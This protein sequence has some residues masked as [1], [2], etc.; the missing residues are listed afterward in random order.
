MRTWAAVLTAVALFWAAGCTTVGIDSIPQGAKVLVDGKWNGAVTPVNVP[1][2]DLPRGTHTITVEKEGYKMVSP[3]PQVTIS[4][5]GNWILMTC[6]PPAGPLAILPAELCGNL[7]KKAEDS[8]GQISFGQMCLALDTSVLLKESPDPAQPAAGT[9]PERLIR[10]LGARNDPFDVPFIINVHDAVL[11]E[12]VADLVAQVNGARLNTGVI[13]SGVLYFS[14][15]EV[16]IDKDAVGR[17]TC[18]LPCT[19]FKAALDAFLL[20][21]RC[22][23]TCTKEQKNEKAPMAY[24]YKIRV[25]RDVERAE[26]AEISRMKPDLR[27]LLVS[28]ESSLT[29]ARWRNE[30]LVDAKKQQL[31]ALLRDSK[32]AELI[33]LAGKI[34]HTILDCARAR[35]ALKDQSQRAAEPAAQP[36]AP[37]QVNEQRE[38]SLVLKERIE[39]LAP[40]LDAINAEIATRSK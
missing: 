13:K 16:T 36:G 14:A 22:T 33:D 1:V 20:P 4:T 11:G 35:E 31:P 5:D 10:C 12:A 7:W 39:L 6:I 37:P 19:T 2:R 3:P 40:I 34:E 26:A 29:V 9:A 24:V 21:N 23:W 18:N 17:V 38:L 28:E 15:V 8:H 25:S 27:K 32:N 30:M